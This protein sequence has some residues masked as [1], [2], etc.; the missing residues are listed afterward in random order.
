MATTLAYGKYYRDV[1][2][3]KAGWSVVHGDKCVFLGS[4]GDG[5]KIITAYISKSKAAVFAG[6]VAIENKEV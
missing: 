5:V 1:Y 2:Q 3:G 6:R 4:D